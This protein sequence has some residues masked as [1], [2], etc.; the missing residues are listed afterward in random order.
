MMSGPD[1]GALPMISR[2]GL[3]GNAGCAA[4]AAG[5]RQSDTAIATSIVRTPMASSSVMFWLP[6]QVNEGMAPGQPVFQAQLTE[7]K[8]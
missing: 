4:R 8:S 2:I 5:D 6:G 3:S 1:P 7:A